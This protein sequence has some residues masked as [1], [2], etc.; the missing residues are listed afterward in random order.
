MSG[1]SMSN[2]SRRIEEDARFEEN[3]PL[4]RAFRE[5]LDRVVVALRE[6][7]LADS[8]DTTPGNADEVAAI[9]AVV[10]D[11]ATLA[12]VREMLDRLGSETYIPVLGSEYR[13]HHTA[14]RVMREAIDGGS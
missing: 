5:H 4:R 10:D 7:E 12:R 13:A 11:A 9:R 1:G 14:V 6:I 8:D 2:L 3:T